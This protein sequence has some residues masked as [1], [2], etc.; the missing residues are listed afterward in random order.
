MTY[1][2]LRLNGDGC[3]NTTLTN[4]GYNFTQKLQY[5]TELTLAKRT[6]LSSN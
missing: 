6:Y 1:I 4:N 3:M 2:P 5:S